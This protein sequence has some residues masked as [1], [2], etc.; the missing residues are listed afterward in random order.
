MTK[1][2]DCYFPGRCFPAVSVTGGRCA[3]MCKHCSGVFLRRMEH[4]DGPESLIELAVRISDAGGEGFLLTGGSDGSGKVPLQRFADAI[5]TVKEAT[6]LRV[7]AHV[8]LMSRTE[9]EALVSSGV[10]AFSVDVFGSDSAIK[11]TM[12]IDAHVSD[13]L[14][15]IGDL[16]DLG[17]PIIAPH[18]CVGI[19]EG[20]VVGEYAAIRSLVPHAPDALVI[21]ALMPTKGTPYECVPPPSSGSILDVIKAARAAL[22]Q[23]RILLGCMRP[24]GDR[25]WE[26]KAV[27]AGIDGIAMP[28]QG[29]VQSLAEN[30]WRVTE[31]RMCCAIR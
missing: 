12:G 14:S 23:S 7:N 4:V 3:L 20:Q 24:R 21:I 10:D 19:E 15:V 25:S 1:A 8:G 16:R 31:K 18:I 26:E 29:T 2:I 30:G 11:K 27:K 17:A 22:P 5:S 6:T 9:L 28:S 13:F